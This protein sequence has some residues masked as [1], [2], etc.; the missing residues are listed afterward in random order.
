MQYNYDY[1]ISYAHKDNKLPDGKPGFVN[2]FVEKLKN[3]SEEHKKIFGGEI[4][5]FFDETEIPDMSH[6]DND[7]RSK[8]A[9]SRFL[10]VLLSPNYFKS[11]YCAK[12]FD[13][14]MKHEMHRCTLGE[15]TAPMIISNVGVFDPA[16]T[17]TPEIPKNIQIRFPNW[18]SQIQ[19]YQSKNF[20][21]HDFLVAKID[22]VLKTLR[23]EVKNKVRHQDMED[24]VPRGINYPCYNEN[25]VGRR[26]KLLSLRK[27]IIS[28]S[29]KV[30]SAITGLGGFGKTELALTYGHAFG[31]DYQMGR[32]F[33][34]CENCS[35]IYHAILTC[36]ITEMYDWKL[37]GNNQKRLKAL[38]ENLKAEQDRIILQNKRPETLKEEVN[39]LKSE[40]EELEKEE[41]KEDAEKL[42]AKAQKL[43]IEADKLIAAKSKV[44][45]KEGAHLLLILDNVTNPDLIS[46][47]LKLDL[48]DYFHVII[49]MREKATKLTGVHWESVERLSEDESV[50]LLRNLRPFGKDPKEAEAARKIAKLLAGFTLTVE[51]TGS[52]LASNIDVSEITYQ[53]QYKQLVNDLENTFQKMVDEIGDLTRHPAETMTAVLKS[54]L[55]A[56]S[57]N[58]RKAFEFASFMAS[59]AVALTWLPELCGLNEDEGVTVL[60]ELTRYSLLTPLENER[61]IARMHR[62]VADAI[63]RKI[64][65]EFSDETVSEII[66]AIWKKC[67]ILLQKDM[68]FWYTSE[69][70]WNIIPIYEFL[71]IITNLSTEYPEDEIDENVVWSL[72]T[73]GTLLKTLGKMNEAKEVFQC[74]LD[75]SKSRANSFPSNIKIQMNLSASYGNLGDLETLAGNI[76]DARTWYNKALDINKRLVEMN[77]EDAKAQSA[78]SKLFAQ[79]GQLEIIA[80]HLTKSREF[81]KNA[82][83]IA[84]QLANQFSEDQ[85]P[86]NI[87][88]L[89]ELSYWYTKLAY[90]AGNAAECQKWIEAALD[91]W[92]KL[93]KMKPKDIVIQQ[94]L[95]L[96]YSQFGL[97]EKASGNKDSARENYKNA[98]AIIKRLNEQMPKNVDILEQLCGLY[99]NLG[100]LEDSAENTADALKWSEKALAI[101]KRLVKII[102]DNVPT[103][104]GTIACYTL[105]GDLEQGSNKV[106][107]H[108]RYKKAL[109]TI[110]I[111][112]DKMKKNEQVQWWLSI[113]YKRFG[114]LEFGA[115]NKTDARKWY[116]K[117][118][119]ICQQISEK[120]LDDLNYQLHLI[121]VYFNLG[122]LEYYAGNKSKAWECYQKF[123]EILWYHLQIIHRKKQKRNGLIFLK[124][125]LYIVTHITTTICIICLF[126]ILFITIFVLLPK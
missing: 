77:P 19:A 78:L 56:V 101:N 96:A 80:G 17:P 86:E 47:L 23:D 84:Q 71:L 20:D 41:Q 43:E 85:S 110:K 26:E 66:N 61:N 114:D 28:K 39:N 3:G 103:Q 72:N 50:E 35:S 18:L 75:F 108:K 120:M 88:T 4:R 123:V 33:K 55:E 49:T 48:P 13:W 57:S 7:I 45:P 25:F 89:K 2:E 10:I 31:W 36:G 32:F 69:N 12:E 104:L 8:L 116:E 125:R 113:L 9:T 6:W 112:S 24:D 64:S 87:Q 16:I 63:H 92:K 82:V 44:L 11:E 37:K 106:A 97:Y 29:G 124:A 67:H 1:F 102:P 81:F 21:M 107:A 91:N 115:E 5:V 34:S 94:G 126:I 76:V 15:G 30:V 46:Q 70:S 58:T 105:I 73:S 22:N 121:G 59:D 54:T 93:S 109:K 40:A 118:E 42:R 111:L 51:L 95:S 65:D 27:Y 99:L 119:K 14:W 53:S 98:L 79:F 52:Y 62:L 100:R 74:L 83:E 90:A 122:N 117:S 60:K 38:F 68:D